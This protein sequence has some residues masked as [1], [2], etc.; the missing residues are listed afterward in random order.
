M[1]AHLEHRVEEIVIAITS[2]HRE[3][4]WKGQT[5]EVAQPAD[6]LAKYLRDPVTHTSR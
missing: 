4:I 5:V 3:P 2:I 6:P 1:R